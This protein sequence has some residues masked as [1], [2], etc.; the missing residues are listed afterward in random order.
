[1]NR[2]IY[3]VIC[4]FLVS[5]PLRSQSIIEKQSLAHLKRVAVAVSIDNLPVLQD[6][7]INQGKIQTLAEHRL[8]ALGINDSDTRNDKQ[9]LLNLDIRLLKN[10]SEAIYCYWIT[11]KL[12]QLVLL[13]KDVQQNST[14]A[15]TWENQDMG[16][17]SEGKLPNLIDEIM[18]E[19]DKFSSDWASVNQK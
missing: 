7:G 16:I 11:V 15:T 14:L 18:S 3:F 13:K 9:G 17:L 2:L 19:V 4:L 1:M 8:L 12:N 5:N 10:G 6:L